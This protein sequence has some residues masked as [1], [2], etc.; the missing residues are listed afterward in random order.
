MTDFVA[1]TSIARRLELACA[2]VDAM[3]AAA[4]DIATPIAIFGGAELSNGAWRDLFDVDALP[5]ELAAQVAGM[6]DAGLE[7]FLFEMVH[8]GRVVTIALHRRL[9]HTVI[10]ACLD[11]E[12]AASDALVDERAARRD[13][14][15]ASA[16]KDRFLAAVSHELRAPITTMLLWERILRDPSSSATLQASAM[17]AIRQSAETQARLVGDLLDVSRGVSGK[18]HIELVPVSVES[19]IAAAILAVMP[20][21]KAKQIAI[22]RRPSAH[23]GTVL[24][25]ATRL[26]QVLG[27]LLTNAVKFTALGGVIIVD[28]QRGETAVT[29][30]VIDS[31]RGIAAEVLPTIFD[32]FEQG[33]DELARNA[34]G[35]GL[36]LAIARQLVVLHGGTLTA[37]SAGLGFGSTFKLVLPSTV[38]LLVAQG[39]ERPT[40]QRVRVLV[41][42]DDA[43][44]RH[45]LALLLDRA[46]AVVETAESAADARARIA[47]AAPHALICDVAMPEEDGYSLLRDLRA[48]GSRIPAI[49]LTAHATAADIERA[50]AAGFEIHLA[51]PVD[52]ST[53]VDN[54]DQLVA[55]ASS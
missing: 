37:K 39:A 7:R 21:A 22:Q 42:D 28:T 26:Q 17:D 27:N 8:R 13:A 43:R 16:L 10:A 49:A 30:E 12:D 19:V 33:D 51:K 11:L 4:D 40:L 48:S 31:G 24:G 38:R 3:P 44:V 18:L 29:I 9:D 20:L 47:Q 32:P 52:F 34:G 53:L 5:V 54:L 50:K 35:L 14:E 45:A 36:G 15:R 55:A 23:A 2:L 1:G 25:D 6:A 46:G 41:I